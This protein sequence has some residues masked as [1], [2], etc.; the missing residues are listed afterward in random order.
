V[1]ADHPKFLPRGLS[2]IEAAHY[3]G[4]S[5]VSF[6]AM[7]EAGTMPKPRRALPTIRKVWDRIEPDEAIS[8]LPHDGDG[9]G[10]DTWHDYGAAQVEAR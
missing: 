3:V 2:R 5:P 8:A 4:V 1:P 10:L 6:D 7:V 9:N